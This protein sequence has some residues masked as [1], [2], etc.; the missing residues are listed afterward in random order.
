MLKQNEIEFL[1]SERGVAHNE[2]AYISIIGVDDFNKQN[3]R[4]FRIW[5]ANTIK[6]TIYMICKK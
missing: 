4:I 2:Q 3:K 6:L 5:V 1:L